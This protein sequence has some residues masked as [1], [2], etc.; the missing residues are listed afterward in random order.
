MKIRRCSDEYR[1][2]RSHPTMWAN[3]SN[4]V[5][6]FRV[7]LLDANLADKV[8]GRPDTNWPF[9]GLRVPQSKIG[10][11]EVRP[12][13]HGFYLILLFP[14]LLTYKNRGPCGSH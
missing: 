2:L 10:P 5:S 13:A 11:T 1:N 6:Q 9:F 12:R 3:P 8:S 4:S 7:R 14:M